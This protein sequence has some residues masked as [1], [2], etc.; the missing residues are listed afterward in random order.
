MVLNCQTQ[1]NNLYGNSPQ[2][3][4]SHIESSGNVSLEYVDP[5]VYF[6]TSKRRIAIVLGNTI[7]FLNRFL[8]MIVV[9]PATGSSQR[10]RWDEHCC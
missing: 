4:I 1:A 10:F 6:V 9:G 5:L 7:D 8:V 3:N 2:L